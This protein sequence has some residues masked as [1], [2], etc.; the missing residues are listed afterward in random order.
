MIFNL[1]NYLPNFQVSCR[2]KVVF[3]S[4]IAENFIWKIEWKCCIRHKR[5][6]CQ[7]KHK[8]GWKYV[9]NVH[10]DYR[11][12]G[13]FLDS[14]VF[15]KAWNIPIV[16][17]PLCCWSHYRKTKSIYSVLHFS[18]HMHPGKSKES[19]QNMQIL[20]DPG[21]LHQGAVRPDLRT[22]HEKNNQGIDMANSLWHM[23]SYQMSVF[24]GVSCR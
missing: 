24:E 16:T 10:C 12:E 21:K 17:A 11:N 14:H 2:A 20:C 3:L 15:R 8:N 1:C 19:G 5:S 6:V 23:F 22:C 13:F 7:K 18:L 4:Y 9:E